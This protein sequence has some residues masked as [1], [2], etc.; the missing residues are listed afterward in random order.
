M[1]RVMTASCEA[2]SLLFSPHPYES[3]GQATDL[4]HRVQ[5]SAVPLSALR[6]Q[7][8]FQCDPA[9]SRELQQ[10]SAGINLHINNRKMEII[11]DKPLKFLR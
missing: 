10:V 7:T 4:L 6:W 2:N 9:I 3:L 5:A 8:C 11:S 1:K